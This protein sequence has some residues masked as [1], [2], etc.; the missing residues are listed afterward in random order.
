MTLKKGSGKRMRGTEGIMDQ[1]PL[2]PTHAGQRRMVFIVVAA[3]TLIAG[4]SL[5]IWAAGTRAPP[6]PPTPA[7]SAASRPL[8]D[9]VLDTT[10]ALQLTLQ[11]TIDQLQ[12]VQDQLAAQKLETQKLK[13]QISDI[14]EKLAAVQNSGTA[15]SPTATV[16]PKSHR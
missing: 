7:V 10:R 8:T 14:T 3:L 5:T 1:G 15:A 2:R 4:G 13:D 12:V 9:D 16:P 11:E 6:A